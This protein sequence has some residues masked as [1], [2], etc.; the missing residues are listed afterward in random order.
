MKPTLKRDS[1]TNLVAMTESGSKRQKPD[2]E[3]ASPASLKERFNVAISHLPKI[4]S[5]KTVFSEFGWEKLVALENYTVV[6]SVIPY[7][8][9][10]KGFD[11]LDP[12]ITDSLVFE[13]QALGMNTVNNIKVRSFAMAQGYDLVVKAEDGYLMARSMTFRGDWAYGYDRCFQTKQPNLLL[14]LLEELDSVL[15]LEAVKIS[16]TNLGNLVKNV[17]SL[18][19]VPDPAIEGLTAILKLVNEDP[20]KVA[21]WIVDT[22]L[23]P[24]YDAL[25]NNTRSIYDAVV[26]AAMSSVP[27]MELV[28]T[29]ES[30]GQTRAQKQTVLVSHPSFAIP[31][32]VHGRDSFVD[33]EGQQAVKKEI[34]D[35]VTT[36][37]VL[38]TEKY[39]TM[40]AVAP[41]APSTLVYT[42]PIY[43]LVPKKGSKD[44]VKANQPTAG[45]LVCA[46]L[47]K[48][49]VS[50]NAKEEKN[51][52]S[53]SMSQAS[54]SSVRV[55]LVE[56]EE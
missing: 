56:M 13:G 6:P 40:A 19:K 34:K 15:N 52:A 55:E 20:S 41:L 16:R 33:Q 9:L 2:T 3:V 51:I 38:C 42:T 31:Y 14:P 53:G 48:Y 4:T 12:A 11:L 36:D 25:K 22:D 50:L 45:R 30:S 7:L 46:D 26:A 49:V 29:L 18:T 32:P 37:S 24:G 10:P 54:G 27:V 28:G 39:V 17:F 35:L 43:S 23:P 47:I 5:S 21:S 1:K 8:H 44:K